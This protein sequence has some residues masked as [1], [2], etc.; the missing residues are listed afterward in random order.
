MNILQ[1][2]QSNNGFHCMQLF[3]TIYFFRFILSFSTHI[4]AGNTNN[5]VNKHIYHIW[6]IKPSPPLQ[7]DFRNLYRI[8]AFHFFNVLAHSW[9]RNNKKCKESTSNSLKYR[10]YIKIL[11]LGNFHD[12]LY[13]V[14]LFSTINFRKKPF[15][16]EFS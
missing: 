4:H 9:S 14:E 8:G 5:A 7:Q 2:A 12:H 10:N 1:L 16:R 3:T 6:K 11:T 13:Q 15:L